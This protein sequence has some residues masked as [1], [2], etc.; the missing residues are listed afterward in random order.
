MRLSHYEVP[1]YIVG[2]KVAPKILIFIV[3]NDVVPQTMIF[4]LLFTFCIGD[5][6]LIDYDIRVGSSW[7]EDA[8]ETDIDFH[9]KKS[10][11]HI[12]T[13]IL[14]D[15]RK[16]F[17]LEGQSLNL[18]QFNSAHLYGFIY[19]LHIQSIGNKSSESQT[20]LQKRLFEG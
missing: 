9:T 11:H 6:A 20:Y 5:F 10:H 19:P 4:V 12:M 3:G 16:M 2:S 18:I 14:T 13:R 8:T 1:M 7:L 17:H 15:L